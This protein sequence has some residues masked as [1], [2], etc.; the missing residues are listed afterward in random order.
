M[1]LAEID[2]NGKG[3]QFFGKTKV[4]RLEK[5]EGQPNVY[6]LQTTIECER[7]NQAVPKAGQFYLIRSAK[8][9]V[10]YNR[11]ISVYHSEEPSP[12]RI[13]ETPLIPKRSLS[14]AK[15]VTIQAG[16]RL[17]SAHPG[18]CAHLRSRHLRLGIV[19]G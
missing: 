18:G 16:L 8:S 10:H 2:E 14:D 19:C 5:I 11:P 12:R 15:S 17:F 13:S 3:L 9:S 7:P 4:E 6:L 1:D